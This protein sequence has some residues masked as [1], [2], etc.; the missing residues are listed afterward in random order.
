MRQCACKIIKERLAVVVVEWRDVSAEGCQECLTLKL[1]PPSRETSLTYAYALAL[2]DKSLGVL[3][4]S[5]Q[6]ARVKYVNEIRDKAARAA[7]GND[8]QT[9]YTCVRK[10]QS[11]KTRLPSGV[12][13]EAVR[14]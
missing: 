13:W 5:L 10:L 2:L 6:D 1:L 12:L 9:L 3:R 11:S 14:P 7:A 4:A 8:T